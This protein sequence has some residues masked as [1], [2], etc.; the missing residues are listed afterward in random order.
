MKRPK[1]RGETQKHCAAASTT[2][3]QAGYAI[4]IKQ[5]FNCKGEHMR[6]IATGALALLSGL[7]P[8]NTMANEQLTQK[9]ACVGCHQ[10]EKKVVG[11]SWSSIRAKY[12]GSV[13]PD[14]L[15]KS[16]KAGSSGKWG[17]IPMPAQATVSDADALAIATWILSEH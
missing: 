1:H 12:K 4:E 3:I 9:H 15:A 11:P 10:A 7:S 14:Q 8:L 2:W 13:T 16:I 6:V 17:P 5:F